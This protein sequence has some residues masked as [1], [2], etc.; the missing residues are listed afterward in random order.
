MFCLAFAAATMQTYQKNGILNGLRSY[1][2]KIFSST[3]TVVIAAC[4]VLSI[5]MPHCTQTEIQ[6]D[7]TPY[8][9]DAPEKL[10]SV[11]DPENDPL[12][13][14]KTANLILIINKR[15]FPSC[16]SCHYPIFFASVS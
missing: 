6:R 14:I 5:C 3:P 9:S 16:H 8:M 2:S 10:L 1:M 7:I 15:S 4:S 11:V 13:A 12:G